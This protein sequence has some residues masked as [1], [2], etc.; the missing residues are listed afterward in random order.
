MKDATPGRITIRKPDDWHLHLRDGAMLQAVAPESARH[1][2]RAIIMPNLVPPVA[3]A[4]QALAYRDRILAALPEGSG[5]TP[6]M[7]LY[8]TEDTDPADLRRAHARG[9]ATAVKL[10][11]AGATTNSVSGVRDFDK[12]RAVFET[13]ADIGMPLCVHGEVTD[14]HVDIFDREAVFI[15]KVLKPIRKKTPD[16]RVVMEHVTTADAVDYVRDSPKNIAATITTHHLI[17]N[18]NH[19]LAGG[20][21][22]HF[23]CLP[24]AKRERHRVA[25]VQAAVSG[26]PRFFL[27]TDSAPHSD[28]AKLQPCGCAGIFTAPNTLSCLA[29]VFEAAG[30]LSHLEAFTSLN[31]PRF[32]RL[33]VNDETVTLVKGA[34]VEYPARIET[35]DGPVTVF[36][37]GFPLH[38]RVEN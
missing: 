21:K 22:P 37:P 10:Y 13:M 34:P 18:R 16:L 9:I 12:V 23:Y 19:I 36:D 26:D 35:G 14:S 24:V 27:G 2:G 32:Y 17:I 7:T 38:W 15:D 30:R 4:D 20:I 28:A 8:L 31:G 25:L 33:P 6:L 11:P 5:F 1:F 3:T 29:E